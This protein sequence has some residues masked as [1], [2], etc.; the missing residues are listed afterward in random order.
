MS[1]REAEA[2]ELV[3]HC[4]NYKKVERMNVNELAQ[5]RF[6]IPARGPTAGK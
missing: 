5:V 6:I 3:E 4:Q 1:T 2:G